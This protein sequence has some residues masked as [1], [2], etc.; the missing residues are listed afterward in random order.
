MSSEPQR[1]SKDNIVALAV[2][3]FGAL[4]AWSAMGQAAIAC[5]DDEVFIDGH[6]CKHGQA[7]GT[8]S[9][10]CIDVPIKCLKGQLAIDNHCCWPGQNWDGEQHRCMGHHTSCPN[11]KFPARI[12]LSRTN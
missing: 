8:A 5:E 7:W 6:C 2:P 3:L 11:L 10:T 9:Q 12:T 1:V 4:V